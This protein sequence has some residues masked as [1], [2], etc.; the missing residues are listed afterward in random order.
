MFHLPHNAILPQEVKFIL[1]QIDISKDYY[2]Y[3]ELKA[4]M[5]EQEIKHGVFPSFHKGMYKNFMDHPVFRNY[6]EQIAN[7]KTNYDLIKR[8]QYTPNKTLN[9]CWN[10]QARDYFEF[11]AFMGLMPSYY[12]GGASENEKRYYVG[13]TLKQYKRGELS[14]RDLLFKM[15]YRNASKNSENIEQYDVRNRPFVVALK[16][17]DIFKQKGFKRVDCHTLSYLI[18]TTKDEDKIDL[19]GVKLL[20]QDD[21]DKTELKEIKRGSTFL[22]QHIRDVL[23]IKEITVGRRT[24]FDLNDFDINNYNFKSKA[25]FIGDFYPKEDIEITPSVLR[26]M[27]NPSIFQKSELKSKLKSIGLINDTEALYDFNIDTDLQDRNL[28][29][30]FLKEQVSQEF[31]PSGRIEATEV[32]KCGKAVSEASDGTAYEEFLYKFL[33]DKFGKDRVTYFGANTLAQRLS[34]IVIDM[35]IINDDGSQDNIKIIVEA[36]AGNAIRA[37]DE[38]K[39]INNITNT[40]NRY[41]FNDYNGVWYIIADSNSIPNS[42]GHGGFRQ[43]N[44]QVSF[45]RKLFTI[46]SH[47]M[48]AKL[49]MVTAFSYT[50]FMK[51]IDSINYDKSKGY[52]TRI[53]A[54]NFWTWSNFVQD[55]YIGIRA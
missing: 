26:C 2:L 38:R 21:F 17:M 22:R 8:T 20:N 40:L 15:K 23:N 39:E 42:T 7:G 24:Y 25:V 53:H 6:Y 11:F 47:I 46:H 35:P 44:E 49:A 34:D 54:P 43:N 32:F 51:F 19:D 1:E 5:F 27:A 55:S 29:L 14:F 28:V 37:F 52:L 30:Q 12:K 41:N 50:E 3:D 13:E 48:R 4:L 9:G 16:L 33:S 45:K 31:V 10:E 36:K 18:R